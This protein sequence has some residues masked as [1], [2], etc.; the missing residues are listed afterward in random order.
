MRIYSTD[1]YYVP[2]T[3][4]GAVETKWK[5]N[6]FSA[7]QGLKMAQLK[8]L[9]KSSKWSLMNKVLHLLRKGEAGKVVPWLTY[10]FLSPQQT[11][12]DPSPY[13]TSR[14]EHRNIAFPLLVTP[15][16]SRLVVTCRTGSDWGR[17]WM[18]LL[19]KSTLTIAIQT[20]NIY[21]TPS[22]HQ[23][24]KTSDFHKCQPH[25]NATG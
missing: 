6:V 25:S 20:I 10:H 23:A 9:V 11:H 22:M 17:S 2:N 24:H 14:T 15:A 13:L 12:C 18:S 1:I 4:L 7:L 16:F 3:R 21:W 8:K 19:P 5:K